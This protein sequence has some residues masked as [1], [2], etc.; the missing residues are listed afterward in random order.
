M[1]LYEKIRQEELGFRLPTYTEKAKKLNSQI[2]FHAFIFSCG[3]SKKTNRTLNEINHQSEYIVSDPLNINLLNTKIA[4]G[5]VLRLS[6]ALI[7]N[8]FYVLNQEE[9]LAAVL[10][11]G[12]S[13]IIGSGNSIKQEIILEI[14][15]MKRSVCN[16][17][18]LTAGEK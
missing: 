13:Y 7:E 8:K 17:I 14:K 3:S 11:Y 16:G 6:L 9:K 15:G 18:Q 4:A 10:D 5:E 12:F 1:F 2:Q